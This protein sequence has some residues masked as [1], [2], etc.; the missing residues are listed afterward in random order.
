MKK[1]TFLSIAVLGAVFILS[2]AE[3]RT[4]HRS[5]NAAIRVIP[6]VSGLDA[7]RDTVRTATFSARASGGGYIPNTIRQRAYRRA[8][9]CINS[10]WADPLSG[11]ARGIPAECTNSGGDGVYGFNPSPSLLGD[12]ANR[13]CRAWP[14]H[15][16]RDVSVRIT[17]D[18]WGDKGCGGRKLSKRTYFQL[19][20][21]PTFPQYM[22][23]VPSRCE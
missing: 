1:W 17:A 19:A 12:M 6:L 2:T 22:L 13:A 23:Y 10:A 14:S 11:S 21:P 4:Y 8:R 5:C 15:R 9:N 16:G 18:I 20:G 7:V 3:A